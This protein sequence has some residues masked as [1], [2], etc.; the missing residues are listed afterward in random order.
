MTINMERALLCYQTDQSDSDHQWSCEWLSF[1]VQSTVSV[2]RLC[3]TELGRV[4]A[5]VIVA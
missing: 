4:F 3:D 2:C 1:L 5:A